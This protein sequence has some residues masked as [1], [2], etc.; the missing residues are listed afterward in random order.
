[1]AW[2][3]QREE[4][5]HQEG[6]SC[7]PPPIAFSGLAV[8]LEVQGRK[9]LPSPPFGEAAGDTAPDSPHY[10][11]WTEW[12]VGRIPLWQQVE[13]GGRLSRSWRGQPL[14]PAPPHARAGGWVER[15]QDWP[16]VPAGDF[17]SSGH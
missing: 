13:G 17:F 2:R 7:C 11:H 4:K 12:Q 8:G 1:M 3:M 10:S 16:V 6:P 14:S 15:E 9:T 5:E